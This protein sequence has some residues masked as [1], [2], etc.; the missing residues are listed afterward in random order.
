VFGMIKKEFSDDYFDEALK[1]IIKEKK[2]TYDELTKKSK[3]SK[4][5]LTQIIVH[6]KIPSKEIIEKISKA[7]NIKPD[8]FKEYRILKFVENLEKYHWILNSDDELQLD[9][10]IY[11][12]KARIK[13]LKN[14][15]K[16]H[17][18]L[19]GNN[20]IEYNPTYILNL[21]TLDEN[22]RKIIKMIYDEFVSIY[23]GM[24]ANAIRTIKTLE[25]LDEKGNE[26]QYAEYLNFLE[27]GEKR[28][29]EDM[30]KRNTNKKTM[31]NK[32]K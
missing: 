16:K 21:S 4:T 6:G 7:I 17:D 23:D 11:D 15:S 12:I 31:N 26:K 19:R 27:D 32:N 29:H 14:N 24:D 2:I 8:Y 1:R 22:Q 25:K 5:Y 10:I 30:D 3:V 20:R 18:K 28:F 9:K 13:G